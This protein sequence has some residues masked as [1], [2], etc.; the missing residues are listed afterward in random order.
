[1]LAVSIIADAN[2]AAVILSGG[3]GLMRCSRSQP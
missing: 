3:I 1:M 2:I